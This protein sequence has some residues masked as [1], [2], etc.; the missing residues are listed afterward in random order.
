MTVNEQGDIVTKDDYYP[1]G[2]RMPGLSY[3]NGNENDRLKF[4]SKRLQDYGFWET[5]YFGWRDYDPELGRW[6]VVDPA[7]QYDSPYLYG[8]NNPIVGIEKDGRWFWIA[9]YYA[10]K[11]YEIYTIASTVYNLVN[12]YQQGGVAGLIQ[13]GMAMGASFMVGGAAGSIVGGGL[14]GGAISG[15]LTG[16]VT[17]AMYG[18]SFWDGAK[19]GAV[20]GAISGAMNTIGRDAELF[21]EANE[22]ENPIKVET[23][24]D[25]LKRVVKES[26]IKKPEM[27]QVK[28]ATNENLK[29]YGDYLNGNLIETPRSFWEWILRGKRKFALGKTYPYAPGSRLSSIMIAPGAFKSYNLLTIVVGHELIHANHINIGLDLFNKINLK[30][31]EYSAYMWSKSKAFRL[32]EIE[33]YNKIDWRLQN[34]YRGYYDVKFF[35]GPFL[36][37]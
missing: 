6:F 24:Q 31:S 8:G 10:W 25:L 16:G 37:H 18:G 26:E 35:Y 33:L 17:S 7:R 14:L 30:K 21:M 15:G 19:I 12:A 4:Q 28:I 29:K 2:L 13:S 1:F 23:N 34:K 22:G 5:Y 20:S 11:A 3:N 36:K 9:A 27:T 32:G